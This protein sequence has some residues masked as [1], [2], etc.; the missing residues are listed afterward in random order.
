MRDR[1]TVRATEA[2]SG[3]NTQAE[4]PPTRERRRVERER[5]EEARL[6]AYEE[7]M[8]DSLFTSNLDEISEAFAEADADSAR[9]ID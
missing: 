1:P 3:S 2:D 6:A 5:R 7:A 8:R 4:N 9:F